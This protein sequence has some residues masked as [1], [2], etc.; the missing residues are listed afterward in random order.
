MPRLQVVYRLYAVGGRTRTR[1]AFM[2]LE[3]RHSGRVDI[4]MFWK[5]IAASLRHSPGRSGREAFLRDHLVSLA[6]TDIV[7][8]QVHLERSCQRAY[9]YNLWAA[10]TW[11]LGGW[12]S[13]DGFDGIS[14]D[15]FEDFRRWLVGRGR[16]VFER[17][18]AE[19]DALASFPEIQRLV[20]RSR[21]AW[22]NDVEWPEWELLAYLAAEAYEQTTGSDSAGFYDAVSTASGL[23]LLQYPAGHYWDPSNEADA[24]LK[25]PRLRTM[26]DLNLL[27]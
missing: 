17:S 6:P 2:H 9:T 25:L 15:S 19:P 18:L 27:S 14:E 4:D 10:A 5:L 8:F 16:E 26:F 21:R 3:Q 22:N 7:Q 13:D 23:T 24:S 11:I 20:G 1:Q 12:F